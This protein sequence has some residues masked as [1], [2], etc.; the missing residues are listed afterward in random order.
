MAEEGRDPG[1]PRWLKW[2][3]AILVVVAVGGLL[4]VLRGALTPVFFAFLIAYMLD[5]VVDRMEAR[6]IPRAVGITILLTAFLG[7]LALFVLLVVP[8]VVSEITS[9]ARELPGKLE[10]LLAKV[11]PWLV[12][13]GVPVPHTLEEALEQ[14]QVDEKELAQKAVAPASQVLQ[15][16]VGGTAS[17][18]G[19]V[20]GLLMVP[21]FAFYL[22]YDFDR[23]IA[24]IRDLVPSRVRP[25]VVDIAGEVDEVLGQF[26]RGQLIVMVALA[27]LYAVGYSLLGVRLAVPIAIVAGLVSFI[28]YVGGA[29]SLGLAL[30]M[31]LLHWQ[32]WWQIG[33]V[34]GVYTAVQLLE[35]F[36]ITPRIVGD[37]VGLPAVWVLFALMVGG[38]LFGFMGVLLALPVAAV[39]K[40]FV[41]R[42]LR[43][44]RQSEWYEPEPEPE[45]DAEPEGKGKGKGTG[46]DEG[47]EDD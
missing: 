46:E 42:G 23:M 16:I 32:G 18:I 6:R 7:L 29:V 8:G 9:F 34:V 12:E 22:L 41:G 40:I 25:T 11:E 43:W 10:G 28:P 3:I 24:R 37:K 38:E 26:V 20:A 47:G 21:V 31:C 19:A 13:R 2:A 33:G 27:V 5:P 17:A 15:W 1:M 36:V 39:A 35:G 4:Y 30:L 44:Y 14:A 45:R